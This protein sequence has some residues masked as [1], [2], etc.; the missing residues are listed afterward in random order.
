MPN[1]SLLATLFAATALCATSAQ[2][3]TARTFEGVMRFRGEVEHRTVEMIYMAKGSKVRQEFPIENRRFVMLLDHRSGEMTTLDDE[4]K[5]YIVRNLHDLSGDDGEMPKITRLAGA[6]RILGHD[7]EHFLIES[8]DV[9]LKAEVCA[10]KGLGL[11]NGGSDMSW[12]PGNSASQRALVA[13]NTEYARILREGFLPLK[14]TTISEDGTRATMV[15][16]SVEA[17]QLDASVFMPPVGYT[18]VQLPAGFG[19]RP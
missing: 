8:P 3:Q 14:F 10:A 5:S 7:C 18:R 2:S 19:G 15:A 17:K 16:T 6:E 12:A 1:Q 11:F 9:D 13:K 4:H